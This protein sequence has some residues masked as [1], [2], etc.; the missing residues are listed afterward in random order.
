[1]S[2]QGKSKG[3]PVRFSRRRER[4]HLRERNGNGTG[5]VLAGEGEGRGSGSS[6]FD[7]VACVLGVC[8]KLDLL[9]GEG[10]VKNASHAESRMH[11]LHFISDEVTLSRHRSHEKHA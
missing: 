1:M 4:H 7:L 9:S 11:S 3:T 8:G 5:R 6:A 10:R 2:R